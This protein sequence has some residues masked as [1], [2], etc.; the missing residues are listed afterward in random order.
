M[1]LQGLGEPN[2]IELHIPEF[3]LMECVSVLWQHVRRHGLVVNTAKEMVQTLLDLTLHVHLA[4]HL[5]PRAFEIAT[6][7]G[8]A[9]YDSIHVA[10]A[11]QL[12]CP[13]IT[14]D[15]RQG[16]VAAAV[17]IVIKPIT[18]FPEFVEPEE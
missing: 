12:G 15:E 16:K 8:L 7:H 5:L 11:E 13:L 3:T 9:I 2:A 6:D 14:N 1:L 17:G 4:A 18:D 10:L